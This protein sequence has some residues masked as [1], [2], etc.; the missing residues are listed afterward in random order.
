MAE[1]FQLLGLPRQRSILEP[2]Q[3]SIPGLLQS[4]H[5]IGTDTK[6]EYLYFRNILFAQA[7]L[8]YLSSALVESLIINIWKRDTI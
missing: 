4:L 7:N 3:K 6:A 2:T 1:G 5:V 8:P